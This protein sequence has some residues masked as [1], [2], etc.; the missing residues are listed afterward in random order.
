MMRS[1][2]PSTH[3]WE[4]KKKRECKDKGQS[5]KKTTVP[6][7]QSATCR[8]GERD[9]WSPSRRPTSASTPRPGRRAR[10]DTGHRGRRC[11]PAR[12]NPRERPLSHRRACGRP[13]CPSAEL[14]A[15]LGG[16]G[17]TQGR[18]YPSGACRS[19][20]PERTDASARREATPARPSGGRIRRVPSTP[21]RGAP[22]S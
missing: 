14:R 13:R 5:V 6:Q 21:T 3:K 8:S 19:C 17:T 18:S 7:V 15:R 10:R 16:S 4:C 12:P 9:C 2:A 1:T 11:G 20:F 22:T